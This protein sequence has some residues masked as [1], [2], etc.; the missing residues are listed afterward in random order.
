MR[1]RCPHHQKVKIN[2]VQLEISFYTLRAS[3]KYVELITAIVGTIYYYK[4]RHTF[5][6]YFLV[7][8]WYTAINEFVGYGI[9]KII[10]DYNIII[11]NIFH[12]V[13]FSFLFLLFR[14]YVEK[15]NHK[16]WIQWFFLA[17]VFS[18]FINMFFE[19]Y[20]YEIQTIPFFI[21]SLG[22][23]ISILFYFSQILNSTEVL[24]VRSYLLFWISI[25][26][27]LYLTGNLPIRIIR[28]F[29]NSDKDIYLLQNI[30][31]STSILSIVMNI[32]FIL[33]FIWLKKDKQY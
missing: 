19:N 12:L 9:R 29:F 23:I 21:A 30:L 24:Y 20:F 16:K 18:F 26:Y 10:S 6:K 15:K 7:I 17:Y 27:F 1:E 2:N 3:I 14:R 22:I 31:N 13:N 5:L 28:N 33:G 11:Y 4:Y 25:G 32:C 8:L